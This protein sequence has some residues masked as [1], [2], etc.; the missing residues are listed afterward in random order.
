MGVGGAITDDGKASDGIRNG[1][2]TRDG[3][4]VTVCSLDDGSDGVV[5]CCVK[6]WGS[7]DD[8]V[9]VEFSRVQK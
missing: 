8:S 3:H 6:T 2:W 9:K 4:I 5:N 7:C 1:V